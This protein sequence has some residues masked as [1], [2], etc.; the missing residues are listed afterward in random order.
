ML[1]TF[2]E[3]SQVMNLGFLSCQNVLDV[4]SFRSLAMGTKMTFL[5]ILLLSF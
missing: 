2:I 4:L 5:L 1:M 3:L